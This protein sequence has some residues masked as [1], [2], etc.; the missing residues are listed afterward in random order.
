MQF[1]DLSRTPANGEPGV[2][3]LI[4]ESDGLA[5][6]VLGNLPHGAAISPRNLEAARQLRGWLAAWIRSQGGPDEDAIGRQVIELLNLRVKAN[7]R[8]DTSGGD[9]TPTGLVRTLARYLDG[10]G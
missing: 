6:R 7:G 2:S 1:I 10:R 5:L 9:K 8:V 3:S 4:A